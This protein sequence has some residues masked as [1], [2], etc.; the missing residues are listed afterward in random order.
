M[1]TV[2]Q[3]SP[4]NGREI[5]HRRYRVGE[6]LRHALGDVFLRGELRDPDLEG[7]SITVSE[8]RVT[9]DLKVA[10]VYVSIFGEFDPKCLLA[11][12]KRATPYLKARVSKT[13]RLRHMPKFVFTVD[14]SV[15]ESDHI[16]DIL[17]RPKVR[18]DLA[19]QFSHE[20]EPSS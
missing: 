5:K 14:P 13:V 6:L 20:D 12:L 9:P 16:T 1:T 19:I 8:V 11:G 17:H 3:P 4:F 2:R 7:A 18:R 10:T 15:A